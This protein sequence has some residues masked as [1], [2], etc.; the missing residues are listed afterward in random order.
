MPLKK[1]VSLETKIRWLAPPV[2]AIFAYAIEFISSFFEHETFSLWVFFWHVFDL[3]VVW[4]ICRWIALKLDRTMPWGARLR[5]R[6]LT[7]IF[8]SALACVVYLDLSYVIGKSL[9]II[10]GHQH[11]AISW[12][13]LTMASSTAVLQVAFILFL[14]LSMHAV[15]QW[16]EKAL[17]SARF[18]RE[19]IE[20]QFQSLRNQANPHFLFNS[21][22][23]LYGLIHENPQLAGA[24]TL[25]LSDNY[26]YVLTRG[27]E[28][29]VT[30]AE[31][32]AF[33]DNYMFLLKARF[34]KALILEN[35]LLEM[36]PGTII[37]PLSLQLLVENAVKH[38]IVSQHQPL[39]IRLYINE[40]RLIVEN[41]LQPRR[42]PFRST[43]TGLEN[44]ARRYRFLGTEPIRVVKTT[45]MFRV[46]LPISIQK[47]GSKKAHLVLDRFA[48]EVPS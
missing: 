37:P 43:G 9:L 26:R 33:L 20:A 3:Y 31:E 28:E 34:G 25:K 48:Q 40:D 47:R 11:D 39:V 27:I 21:L 35:Q 41:P 42:E 8:F 7:Q 24:F 23:T 10:I 44:L 13:H 12:I 32:L 6:I 45:K 2:I 18:E 30:L 4:E 38:N 15:R 16:K 46:I 36:D 19:S 1:H 29:V 17:E 22:N 14:Q 5:K